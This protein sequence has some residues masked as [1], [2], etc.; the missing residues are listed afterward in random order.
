[1]SINLIGL[2][3]TGSIG[4]GIAQVAAQAG[5][6]VLLF[7]S[8]AGA[9]QEARDAIGEILG[10]LVE[11]GKLAADQVETTMARLSVVNTLQ[12]L[13]PVKLIV[14]SV[15]EDLAVKK[16][17]FADLEDVVADDCILAT[18]TGSL[19]VTAIAAVC[20]LPSRV[21]GFHFSNPVPLMRIVEVVA[22]LLTAPATSDTLVE[23]A[24][25]FDYTA[26]RAKDK[27]GFIINH[28][29]CGL[30][31]E[32]LSL[33]DEQVADFYDIDRIM[34]DVAGFPMGPC[35]LMDL[36][37]MD[38]S[39][40]FMEAI[41]HR[42]DQE[43]RFRP[44]CLAHQR[45]TAGLIGRRTGGGFY[46]YQDDRMIGPSEAL[47][48]FPP[49]VLDMETLPPIWIS[50]AHPEFGQTVHQLV[51]KLGGRI[52]TGLRPSSQA[53]CIITPR[54]T[55]ATTCV[56][57]EGLDARRTVAIDAVFGLEA[58]KRRTLMTTPITNARTRKIAHALFAADGS[59]VTVIHDSAGFVAQRIIAHIVN[60]GCNI[61]QQG[62]ATPEDIDRAVNLGLGY[63]KG[64][65]AFGDAIGPKRV[66]DILDGLYTV[67]R[68]PRYRACPWLRRRA[69]LGV[70]L[71][72]PD[73]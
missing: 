1:M 51:A 10:K 24:R 2:V 37:G 66:L 41:Y 56:S 7:D 43:P 5:I 42:Y 33:L 18:N 45:L 16:Q 38:E 44:S 73:A 70:S 27:P 35:E 71:L 58:G 3:G 17:L 13:A 67:Y 23:L 32:A 47:K 6:D 22:G 59:P 69:L 60:I 65:L 21:V 28:A 4:R 72:T 14:E 39:V 63:P 9:A 62:I 50:Q 54:G 8:R 25:R 12:G 52:E 68:D 40:K 26:V 31:T 29:G 49:P 57:N 55:D 48:E 19:S 11:K 36:T 46:K 64:P 34:R 20:R 15:T 53:L 30:V 61:A